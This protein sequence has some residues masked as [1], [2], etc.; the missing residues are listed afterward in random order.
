MSLVPP[1]G[2]IVVL[3]LVSGHDKKGYILPTVKH[4]FLCQLKQL[5]T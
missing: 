3:Q 5:I 2:Y 4:N 1:T